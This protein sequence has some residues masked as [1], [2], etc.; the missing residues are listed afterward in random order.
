VN[1]KRAVRSKS[2]A[3]SPEAP[4]STFTKSTSV[5]FAVCSSAVVATIAKDAG[6]VIDRATPAPRT[7]E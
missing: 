6:S 3:G 5:T 1:A 7:H 2:I 4:G